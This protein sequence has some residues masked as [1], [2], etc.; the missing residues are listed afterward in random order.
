MP[1]A[2]VE[3]VNEDGDQAESMEDEANN[4]ALSLVSE[5]ELNN[6]NVSYLI[7]TL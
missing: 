2:S 1:G 5:A 7:L 4:S 6:T 3:L